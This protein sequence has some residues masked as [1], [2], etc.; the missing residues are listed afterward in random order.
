MR[1]MRVEKRLGAQRFGTGGVNHLA[2]VEIDPP[3]VQGIG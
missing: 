2:A 3:L 1:G